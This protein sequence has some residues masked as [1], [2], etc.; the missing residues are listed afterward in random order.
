MVDDWMDARR[1]CY[2]GERIASCGE[3]RPEHHAFCEA[4]KSSFGGILTMENKNSRSFVIRTVV[5]H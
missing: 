1:V 2:V 5:A 4:L 3:A